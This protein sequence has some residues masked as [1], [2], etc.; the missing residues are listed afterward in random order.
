MQITPLW[1]KFKKL[2][3][4]DKQIIALQET[5]Q[6]LIN[7]ISIL[8]RLIAKRIT[9][10]D[11]AT[12]L[13]KKNSHAVALREAEIAETLDKIKHKEKQ[14]EAATGPKQ[15][16]ALEHEISSLKKICSDLEDACLIELAELEKT[17]FFME[18]EL[19]TLK[20][21]SIRDRLRAEELKQ[22]LAQAQAN[23]ITQKNEQTT[24]VSSIT[25]AW[26]KKY[27]EMKTHVADP[28]API[29]RNTCGSCFYEVLPQELARLK[30]NAILPCQGC[31]RLLYWDFEETQQ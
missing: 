27:L 17:S 21:A 15:Q 1:Q 5:N 7:E 28:I 31:F 8:D 22:K 3:L 2:G 30:N 29:M 13:H 23:A 16:T 11:Q 12:A 4:L 18:K 24:I 20:E 25:E 14:L 6:E 19:P 26:Y 9:D 10:I